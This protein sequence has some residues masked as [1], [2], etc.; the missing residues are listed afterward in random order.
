M[1]LPAV[2]RGFR[3][4]LA[5]FFDRLGP[6]G[7]VGFVIGLIAGG[8]LTVLSLMHPHMRPS[9]AELLAIIVILSLF[10]WLVMVFISIVFLRCSSGASSR[11]C[12]PVP[13]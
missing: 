12:W 1:R 4:R 6:C 13:S 11:G 9:A 2:R 5:G 8:L 3:G 10:C 7:N